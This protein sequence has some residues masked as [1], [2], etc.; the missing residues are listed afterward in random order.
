MVTSSELALLYNDQSVLENFHAHLGWQLLLKSGV[1]ASL[2]TEFVKQLRGLLITLVLA[3]DMAQHWKVN[4][5][6]TSLL[7][8]QDYQ[9]IQHTC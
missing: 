2:D 3:T 4:T 6:C 5:I 7:K 1:L 8:F 9:R